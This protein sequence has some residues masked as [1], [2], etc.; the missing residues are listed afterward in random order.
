MAELRP[1]FTIYRAVALSASLYSGVGDPDGSWC[2]RE[3]LL[4]HP[5][6]LSHSGLVAAFPSSRTAPASQHHS[7]P[8]SMRHSRPHV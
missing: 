1:P 7:V 4:L 8:P 6:Y 3:N 2:W 5:R